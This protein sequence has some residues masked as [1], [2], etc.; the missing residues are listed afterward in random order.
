MTQAQDT[1][2]ALDDL[3]AA[4]DALEAKQAAAD[5]L[6]AATVAT[7]TKQLHDGTAGLS[8]SEGQAILD[9]IDAIKGE[10]GRGRSGGCGP[11]IRWD[12]QVNG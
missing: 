2:K 9:K 4:I 7:L 1:Q 5:A 3:S 12:E 6:L 10:G 8:A 11:G